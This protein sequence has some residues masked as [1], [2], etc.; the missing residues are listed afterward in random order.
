MGKGGRDRKISPATGHLGLPPATWNE[1]MTESMT[2]DR[3]L[4]RSRRTEWR[5]A[6]R[7]EWRAEWKSPATCIGVGLSALAQPRLT[8]GGQPYLETKAFEQGKP[9]TG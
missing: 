6:L 9:E 7:T 8:K 2:E 3:G 4:N 5:T 1:W